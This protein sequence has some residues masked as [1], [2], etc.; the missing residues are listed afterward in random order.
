M[1]AKGNYERNDNKK[2]AANDPVWFIPYRI[3][4]AK[5][6]SYASGDTE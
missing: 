6:A 2:D 4:V 5:N 1:K 3:E